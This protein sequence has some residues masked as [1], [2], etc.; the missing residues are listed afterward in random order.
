MN[1]TSV[2]TMLFTMV[3]GSSGAGVIIATIVGAIK[4]I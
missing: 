1:E 2:V 3:G 4:A